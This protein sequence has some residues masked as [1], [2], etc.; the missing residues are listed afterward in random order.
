MNK[1][2]FASR[3]DFVIAI[4]FLIFAVSIV[5]IAIFSKSGW[6]KILTLAT[7]SILLF[8]YFWCA[9]TAKYA[10]K[11]DFIWYIRGP[12]KNKIYY[13]DIL[14]TERKLNLIFSPYISIKKI[15]IVTGKKF[16]QFQFVAPKNQE[17]FENEL[18]NRIKNLKNIVERRYE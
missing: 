10:F 13:C 15:K 4:V 3:K 7:L 14:K 16:F 1:T 6:Q 5:L 11:E 2:E 17:L 9:F 12:F 18:K 8:L